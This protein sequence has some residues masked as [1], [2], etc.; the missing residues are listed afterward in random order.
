M[1]RVLLPAPYPRSCWCGDYRQ[2][3]WSHE[4]NVCLTCGTLVSR[5]QLAP[6][7]LEVKKDEGELY[8]KDYWLQRQGDKYGLPPIQRRARN[9][10][11]ERCVHWLREL[12]R[13]KLPGPGARTLELGCAHGGFVALMKW[14]GFEASGIEM[15]PWVVDF[16][17]Q[18]F[19]VD[20][21]VGPLEKR[22]EWQPGTFDAIL[23]NDVIEHLP[24][25]IGTLQTA[26][27]LL[28]SD[29]V[30]LIQ[31]PEYKEHLSWAELEA[32][33]DTATR[34]MA[35]KNEEHLFLYSRRSTQMLWERLGLAVVTHLNPLFPYD[36]AYVASRQLL[37]PHSDAAVEEALCRTPG[38]RLVLA[39]MDNEHQASGW[40]AEAARLR[41]LLP[42]GT[43]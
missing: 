18:T 3:Q 35:G 6:G 23:M 36:M 25:P 41:T 8:S 21:R 14:A 20:V 22:T 17:R 13:H 9:D 32:A 38:G 39:L 24:D 30:M 27:R 31:T 10:L 5:A 26:V 34:P 1:N 42:P 40:R 43:A 28:K 7:A 4:F 11:P 15:S 33:G 37:A 29:G 16:A 2:F 12:L 19:D